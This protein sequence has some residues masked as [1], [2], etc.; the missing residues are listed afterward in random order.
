MGR[1]E[2]MNIFHLKKK[3]IHVLQY[4]TEAQHANQ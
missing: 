4:S 3:N 2:A 1:F